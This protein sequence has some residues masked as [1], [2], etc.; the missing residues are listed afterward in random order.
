MSNIQE[1]D[2]GVKAT[3]PALANMMDELYASVNSTV[4]DSAAKLVRVHDPKLLGIK[5][6]TGSEN[7]LKQ[8]TETVEENN[9]PIGLW[10][11]SE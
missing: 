4:M 8:L 3:L 2:G 1:E 5:L 7:L 10:Q 6:Q 9:G 11:L